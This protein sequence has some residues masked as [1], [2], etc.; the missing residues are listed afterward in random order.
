MVDSTPMCRT[1]R[2]TGDHDAVTPFKNIALHVSIT[3]VNYSQYRSLN[4]KG[5]QFFNEA[6]MPNRIEISHN[7]KKGSKDSTMKFEN[8]QYG[9]RQSKSRNTI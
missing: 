3:L 9:F 5:F 4:T 6:C 1:P 8:K 2:L 7:V